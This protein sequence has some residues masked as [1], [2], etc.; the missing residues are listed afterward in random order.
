MGCNESKQRDV[1]QGDR[2][3]EVRQSDGGSERPKHRES[4]SSRSQPVRIGTPARGEEGAAAGSIEGGPG[5]MDP[6]IP[7]SIDQ[8]NLER[9]FFTQIVSHA[10]DDFIDVGQTAL[11]M[12]PEEAVDEGMLELRHQLKDVALPHGAVIGE[13]L[14]ASALGSGG[15]HASLYDALSADPVSVESVALITQAAALVADGVAGARVSPPSERIV[16]GFSRV[17]KP[18]AAS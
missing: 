7:S 13:A 6:S 17:R 9:Q 8:R 12:D 15:A 16:V 3:R 10:Q 18:E 14:P 11:E 5:R 4:A 1:R 2:R